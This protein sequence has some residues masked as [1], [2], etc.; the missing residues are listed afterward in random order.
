MI[1]KEIDK[2]RINVNT[3]STTKGNI[4][5]DEN[6]LNKYST[7]SEI[8]ANE[9]N[10]C[11]DKIKIK[12]N[13]DEL[14]S[15]DFNCIKISKVK[16][17]AKIIFEHYNEN[18]IFIN[19]GNKILVSK[20]G[21]DEVITKIFESRQ[22]RKYLKEHLLILSVLGDIVEH[23]TLVNQAAEN[24]G[25]IKYNSWNYYYDGLKIGNTIY[26]FEF[27]VVSM[28]NGENHYRIQNLKKVNNKKTE[29]STGSTNSTLPVSENPVSSSNISHYGGIVNTHEI[30]N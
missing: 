7:V 1:T 27:E 15:I 11:N 21:I 9:S 18:N 17:I 12:A 19:D 6:L 4:Q 2:S 22:Q 10:N 29:F 3:V 5:I 28:S 16:C 23:A 25:R 26:N 30:I 24:K 8:F 20:S 14:N 13:I